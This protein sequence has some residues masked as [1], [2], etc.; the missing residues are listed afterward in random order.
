M[1]AVEPG[2]SGERTLLF[3]ALDR[4]RDTVL[5]SLVGIPTP[6]L[7]EPIVSSDPSSLLGVIRRLTVLERWWF[8]YTFAGLDLTVDLPLASERS[9]LRVVGEYHVECARSRRIA[10][11]AGLDDVTVRPGPDGAHVALRSVALRMLAE[12]NRHA[13]RADVIRHLIDGATAT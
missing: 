10:E 3:A 2:T 9:A 6:L 5:A 4:A 11:R 8:A 7:G 1:G 12:T 13:G